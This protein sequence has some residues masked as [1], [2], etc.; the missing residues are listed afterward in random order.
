MNVRQSAFWA[1]YL[2]NKYFENGNIH[3]RNKKE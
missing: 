2:K 1:A 3:E